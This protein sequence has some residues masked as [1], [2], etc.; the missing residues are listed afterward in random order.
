MTI[1]R[2]NINGQN[3]RQQ[4]FLDLVLALQNEE[5]NSVTVTYRVDRSLDLKNKTIYQK[6]IHNGQWIMTMDKGRRCSQ[7]IRVVKENRQ[8]IIQY[9]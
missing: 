5:N 8:Y 3:F 1:S 9:M 4:D 7:P 2:L 6:N